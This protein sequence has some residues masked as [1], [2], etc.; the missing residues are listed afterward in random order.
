MLYKHTCFILLLKCN[1]VSVIV[2]S[3][4]TANNILPSD[5]EGGGRPNAALNVGAKSVCC[6]SLPVSISDFSPPRPELRYAKN[7][8]VRSALLSPPWSPINREGILKHY[9][10]KLSSLKCCGARKGN[11]DKSDVHTPFESCRKSC[12][13]A[14]QAVMKRDFSSLK[15][16]EKLYL[17][18]NLT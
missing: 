2:I 1:K 5:G 7:A 12:A 16:Y 11:V 9:D 13:N 14:D 3:G 17:H 4:R 18:L 8:A 6:T 15:L 10:Q